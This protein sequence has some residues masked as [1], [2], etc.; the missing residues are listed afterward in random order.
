LLELIPYADFVFGN[1]DE[2][3]A[4]GKAVGLEFTNLHD[5][6]T[7]IAKYEWVGTKPWTVTTTQGKNPVLCSVYNHETGDLHTFTTE[8]DV[9]DKE[10]IMDLNG[11][12][13]A[14]V[15]GFLA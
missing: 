8:V 15:G 13:D 7:F 11:A 12:G 3:E 14:F 2:T 5:V 9:I 4:F 6:T 1:E 10:N